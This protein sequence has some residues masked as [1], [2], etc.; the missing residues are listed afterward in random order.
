MRHKHERCIIVD[1]DDTLWDTIHLYREAKNQFRDFMASLG[2]SE[3]STIQKLAHVDAKRF[4]EL[5]VDPKRFPGSMVITYLNLVN[6]DLQNTRDIKIVRRFGESVFSR[7]VQAVSQAINFLESLYVDHNIVL[8]TRG[9]RDIQMKRVN[10]S[11]LQ[12]YFDHIEVVR[13]KT[14]DLFAL[15][16][17]QWSRD[18]AHS[19]SVGDSLQSDVYPAIDAGIHAVWIKKETWRVERGEE[20]E[21]CRYW[22]VRTLAEAVEIIRVNV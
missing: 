21:S 1:G 19:W 8:V 22:Q 20:P 15:I 2:I 9:D 3:Q 6:E 14:K 17:D 16:S 13:E 5:G 18:R 11:G 7:P 10:E 4:A 12:Q